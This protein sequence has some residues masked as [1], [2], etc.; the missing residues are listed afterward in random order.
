LLVE[1]SYFGVIRVWLDN[2]LN[3]TNKAAAQLASPVAESFA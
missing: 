1:R 3:F 2:D